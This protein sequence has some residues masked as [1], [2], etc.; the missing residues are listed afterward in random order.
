MLAAPGGAGTSQWVFLC[1][2]M[3]LH[4]FDSLKIKKGAQSPLERGRV[5]DRAEFNLC[6]K[7]CSKAEEHRG[8]L[9]AETGSSNQHSTHGWEGLCREFTVW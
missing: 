8:G 1:V 3:S 2:S 6:Q 4:F 5:P 9:L 7:A